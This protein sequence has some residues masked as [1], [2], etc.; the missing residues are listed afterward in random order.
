MIACPI[1][2]AIPNSILVAQSIL[3]LERRS[4]FLMRPL[5]RLFRQ[6]FWPRTNGAGTTGTASSSSSR[7]CP[8]SA[9]ART[10]RA[11]G[12]RTTRAT[13]ARTT[14]ATGAR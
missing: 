6:T 5:P 3:F 7:T 4:L 2:I 9:R 12:A 13:G 10:T 1:L 8:T 11:T 14:R